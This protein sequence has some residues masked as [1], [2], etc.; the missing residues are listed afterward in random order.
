MYQF[1]AFYVF[2]QKYMLI[3]EIFFSYFHS[4]EKAMSNMKPKM[5]LWNK[6]ILYSMREVIEDC[7]SVPKLL[8]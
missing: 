6:M 3:H 2:T 8:Y 7:I 5:K 4:T 1:T